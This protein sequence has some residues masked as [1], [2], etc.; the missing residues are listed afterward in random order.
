MSRGHFLISLG[1]AALGALV[2][3]LMAGPEMPGFQRLAAAVTPEVLMPRLADDGSASPYGAVPAAPRPAEGAPAAPPESPEALAAWFR[4]EVMGELE[5]GSTVGP[6]ARRRAAASGSRVR[7]A[8]RPASA[9]ASPPRDSAG[10]SSD[11]SGQ[12]GPDIDWAY[13]RDVFAGRISGIPNETRAGISL[14]EMDELGDIPY[15]EQLRQEERY[16]ELRDLGFENETVPW[17]DCLRTATC[18]RDRASSPP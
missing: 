9:A 14:Q 10:A 4:E 5:R 11:D 2:A 1:L 18:R 17:P 3:L 6:G 13:L 12:S 8:V 7:S 15:I 16:E